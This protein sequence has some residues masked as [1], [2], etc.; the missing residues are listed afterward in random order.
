MDGILGKANPDQRAALQAIRRAVKEIA[1]DAE[2]CVSYGLP[3]FR[4]NGRALVA[5]GAWKDH[6]AFYPMSAATL[7]KFKKSLTGFES[8]K[9]TIRFMPEKPLPHSIVKKL[10]RARIAENAARMKRV[11]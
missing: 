5:F 7:A 8:T 11:L 6:C 3:A 10:V 4:L 9:G 2:E 1:P